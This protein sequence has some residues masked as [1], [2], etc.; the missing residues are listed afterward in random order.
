MAHGLPVC[1]LWFIS[2]RKSTIDFGRISSPNAFLKTQW[3]WGSQ[4][5]SLPKVWFGVL[6]LSI[7]VLCFTYKTNHLK[8]YKAFYSIYYLCHWL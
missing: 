5:G 6:P 2:A 1:D 8:Q 4:D 7:Y 3:A